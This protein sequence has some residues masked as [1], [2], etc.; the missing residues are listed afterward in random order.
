M[1]Q[2]FAYQTKALLRLRWL[3]LSPFRHQKIAAVAVSFSGVKRQ[4]SRFKSLMR[5]YHG[6]AAFLVAYK[7]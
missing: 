2:F 1:E 3:S 5:G 4:M 6:D 7:I